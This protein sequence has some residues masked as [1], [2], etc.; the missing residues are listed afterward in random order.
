M[1][2]KHAIFKEYCSF[3]LG[4]D[5]YCNLL[6]SRDINVKLY[7]PVISYARCLQRNCPFWKE[8]KKGR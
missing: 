8:L 4:E 2:S 5:E 1:K 7:Y 6:K 3:M